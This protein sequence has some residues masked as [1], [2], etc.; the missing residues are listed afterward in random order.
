MIYI[1]EAV[2]NGINAANSAN[3]N[4][5]DASQLLQASAQVV[6]SATA[7]GTVKFQ[8]SN[9]YGNSLNGTVPTNWSDISGQSVTLAGGTVYLIPKFDICYKWLRI[10]YVGGGTGTVSVSIKVHGV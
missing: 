5:L 4:S 8:A 10:A 2:L 9:D 3:S 6:C 1:N 7:T